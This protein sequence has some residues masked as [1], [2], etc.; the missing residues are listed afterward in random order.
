L[1]VQ[2]A[3]IACLCQCRNFLD[4]F[5]DVDG[6]LNHDQPGHAQTLVHS[7]T[8]ERRHGSTIMG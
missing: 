6:L 8:R 1:I 3:A 2:V 4:S 7:I 5:A